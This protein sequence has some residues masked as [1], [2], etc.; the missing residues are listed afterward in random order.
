MEICVNRPVQMINFFGI[1]GKIQPIRFRLEDEEHELQTVS[2]KQIVSVNEVQHVGIESQIFLC[3]GDFV[4]RE[5]LFELR[6]HI[7]GHRWTLFRF[8]Y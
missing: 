2:I 4:G 6:Y 3:R 7:R 1:D 5:R 8:I